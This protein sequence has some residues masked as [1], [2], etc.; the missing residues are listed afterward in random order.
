M[1]RQITRVFSAGVLTDALWSA[2]GFIST[3]T[4]SAML[5]VP[6]TLKV[7]VMGYV[8]NLLTAWGLGTVTSQFAGKRVGNLVFMGG[9]IAVAA[10]VMTNTILPLLPSVIPA[11]P[12]PAGAAGYLPRGTAGLGSYLPYG[13]SVNG[14]SAWS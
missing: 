4:V 5:P 2:T 7:G 8:T 6:S 13:V 11:A 1:P 3:K 12:A 9:V 14:D 10:D